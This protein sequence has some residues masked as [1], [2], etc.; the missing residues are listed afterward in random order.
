MVKTALI[1]GITGQ[2]GAYLSKFLLTKG[3]R[4]IGTYHNKKIINKQRLEYLNISDDIQFLHMDINNKQSIENVLN[5]IKPSELYNLAA[6]SSVGY[7]FKEPILVSEING[8]SV[9]RLLESIRLVNRDIKFFQASSSEMFGKVRSIP[10]NVDTVLYPMSPYAVAKQFAHCMTRNY[11]EAYNIFACSGIMFNHESPLRDLNYVSRKITWSA[12]RIKYGLLKEM[13]LGN[14]DI[15]RDW[16]YAEDYVIA[17]WLMLQQNEPQDFVIAS[18]Q[19][20][21][22]REFIEFTFKEL[23]INIEWI[24]EDTNQIGIDK[25]N[26]NAIIKISSDLFRPSEGNHYQG[27]IIMARDALGW[28]T[29]TGVKELIHKMIDFEINELL[30]KLDRA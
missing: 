27:D 30:N 23:G 5:S 2:D 17:M 26:G 13:I 24:G 28:K 18:G 1:T 7:S 19:T 25:R 9:L 8:F 29:K 3:Y 4:V 20:Y 6:I 22:I 11:R 10:Q 15:K 21:S 12:T 16:G 14:I